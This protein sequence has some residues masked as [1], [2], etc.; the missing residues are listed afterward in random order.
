MT[1]ELDIIVATSYSSSTIIEKSL[2]LVETH[3]VVTPV[4]VNSTKSGGV[5]CKIIDF[6]LFLLVQKRIKN[7]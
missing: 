4:I 6:H 1:V 3:P 2:V 7:I 5:I